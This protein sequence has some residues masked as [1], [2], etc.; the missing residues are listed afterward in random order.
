MRV[1]GADAGPLEFFGLG[2]G[3]DA[4]ASSVI[5]DILAAVDA[6]AHAA[7]LRRRIGADAP[8]VAPLRFTLVERGIPVLA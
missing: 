2:A 3:G 6:R 8:A 7:P 4:S 5:G 1:V